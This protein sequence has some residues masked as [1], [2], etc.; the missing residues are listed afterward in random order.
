MIVPNRLSLRCL[1]ALAL[2]LLAACLNSARGTDALAAEEIPFQE[3]GGDQCFM[4]SM[5]VPYKA[6]ENQMVEQPLHLVINDEDSYKKLFDPKI[7][8]QS[9]A[10]VDLSKVIMGCGLLPAA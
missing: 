2:V 1:R 6:Q 10:G 8:R 9:C 7:M 5:L 4:F 3:L